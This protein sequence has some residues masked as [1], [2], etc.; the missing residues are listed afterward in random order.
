MRSELGSTLS[1]TK[2][3]RLAESDTLPLLFTENLSLPNIAEKATGREQA[4]GS[5]E[6]DDADEGAE[7]SWLDAGLADDEKTVSF[8]S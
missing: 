7:E 1:P 3:L 8:K 2:I 5:P 6:E 4:E